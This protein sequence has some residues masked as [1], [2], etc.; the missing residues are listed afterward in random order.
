[1][2]NRIQALKQERAT[3]QTQLEGYL[4]LEEPT[5][6]NGT[7]ARDWQARIESID[8]DV[9]LAE[10]IAAQARIA[11]ATVIGDSPIAVSEPNLLKDPM[12]GFYD[13]ADFGLAVMHASRTDGFVDPRFGAW[14]S[15][16]KAADPGSTVHKETHSAEGRM[17]PPQVKDDIWAIVFDEDDIVGAVEPEPTSSNSVEWI[18]DETTP[19]G[20]TGVQANWR[21]E[22]SSMTAS[23]LD[24]DGRDVKL[25]E[26]Y[27]FVSA[28]DELLEDAPR[29][30]RRLVQ[31]A[32]RAIGWE[33]SEAIMLGTGSGQPLGWHNTTT[34]P[35]VSVAKESGQVAATVVVANIL[36]MYSRLLVGP[37]ARV[38]WYAN[39]DIV[40][41]L[42]SLS[43]GNEPS[44]T[45]QNAGLREAPSGMLMGYPID[46]SEHCA[47]LGTQGDI[48]L[49]NL[50][51]YY[52]A[53]KT[54]GVKFASSIHLF[55]DYGATAFRWTFRI[56]GQPYLAAA[57]SP[58]KGSNTK[59]HFITLD[60]RS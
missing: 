19:W 55:F 56:G 41:Q 7:E 1:M 50:S 27:A 39:R 58:A 52:A 3:L 18:A 57:V 37:G 31:G 16:I 30:N 45:N 13:A 8:G 36:K 49:V 15:A 5:E 40:P 26:L 59:S 21:A 43:L 22:A 35:L 51:G 44:W 20:S 9:D 60:V 17:V 28:T 38:R 42:S 29:L 46:F 2:S 54:G 48:Q 24:T 32:G 14:D 11:P 47:T 33:A 10:K 4:A 25:H 6:E 23:N 12:A 53:V 34:G